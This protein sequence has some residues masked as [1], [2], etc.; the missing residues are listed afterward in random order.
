MNAIG[1]ETKRRRRCGTC[2]LQHRACRWQRVPASGGGRAFRRKAVH[3]DAGARCIG[4]CAMQH[5]RFRRRWRGPCIAESLAEPRAAP[6]MRPDARLHPRRPDASC[7]AAAHARCLRTKAGP[8]GTSRAGLPGRDDRS[9][10]RPDS[11]KVASTPVR[12]RAAHASAGGSPACAGR[13]ESVPMRHAS[14]PV[15]R[16]DTDGPPRALLRI[17]ADAAAG[18]AGPQSPCRGRTVSSPRRW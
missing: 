11:A 2:R 5:E 12:R 3:S 7:A 1:T 15:G 14:R 8:T 4:R 10:D 16:R 9:C 6:Y 13:G 18:P 17:C